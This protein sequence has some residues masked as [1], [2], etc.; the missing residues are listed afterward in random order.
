MEGVLALVVIVAIPGIVVF[1][2]Y[3]ERKA[4]VINSRHYH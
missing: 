2:G 3:L 1:M 4:G